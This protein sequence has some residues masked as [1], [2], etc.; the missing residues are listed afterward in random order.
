[1][2]GLDV[3]RY[4]GARVAGVNVRTSAWQWGAEHWL[5]REAAGDPTWV[6]AVRAIVARG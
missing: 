4:I 3:Y 2:L 1:V 5:A 6:E